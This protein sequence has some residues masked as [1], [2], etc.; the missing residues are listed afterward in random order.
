MTLCLL[1]GWLVGWLVDRFDVGWRL[2]VG[3]LVG[4]MVVCWLA[5]VGW[6]LVVG[7]CLVL[8][9]DHVLLNAGCRLPVVDCLTCVVECLVPGY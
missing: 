6:L 8:G 4:G 9:I 5:V 7:W 1:A 3:W 2:N